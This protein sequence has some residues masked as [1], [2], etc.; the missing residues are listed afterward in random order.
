MRVLVTGVANGI[1]AA[2]AAALRDAGAQI[3]GVDVVEG[4][5]RR[6][7]LS[8]MS[9]IDAFRF[10]GRFDALV[11]AAGLPPREG[12]EARVLTVNYH[13]LR[14]F[15]ERVIPT[16]SNGGSIVSMASKAGSKWRENLDQVRR[17]QATGPGEVDTFVSAEN[18][19][20]VRSYDLSKEALIVWTKVQTPRLAA[21]G[22]RAN[23]VSPAAVETRI[24]DD[25]MTA[26][27]ERAVRGMALAGRAGTA[28]EIAAV[29]AFLAKPESGWMKGANLVVDGGL[30]AQLEC[31]R[32]GIP[33]AD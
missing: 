9:A 13:G 33:A 22:L 10:D 21:L 3:I 8:D 6:L 12:D 29:A 1:G 16:M 20:A 25:F 5:C 7:D 19:D 26:F 17:F 2:T 18:I 32:L 31:M 27:G 11:N 28:D 14:R 30:D 24:L 23:T 4:D 15:T